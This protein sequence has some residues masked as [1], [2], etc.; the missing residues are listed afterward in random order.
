MDKWKTLDS[1]Y[2]FQTPFGHL[3]KDT[4]ELPDGKVID[5]YYVHEYSDWVN[6]VVLTKENKLVLVE[7]YRHAGEDFYL[8]IPAGK[9]EKDESAEE[10]ILREVRE[11]TGFIS[12]HRPVKLGDFMVNPATQNNRI[13]TYLI[14]DAYREYEQDL[15]ETE[16]VKV[17]LLD[18]EKMGSLIG[19]CEIN[20]Q[21]FTAH[22]YFMAKVYLLEH[23]G[24]S[25][26]Y[27]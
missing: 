18:F 15:D 5:D 19:G 12:K 10:G 13:K 26:T 3:R 11:E 6:A 9:T 4:C 20:T 25:F 2:L 17:V 22:A 16:E 23:S 1:N 14:L 7:Q 21:L 24:G 8:E 27:K